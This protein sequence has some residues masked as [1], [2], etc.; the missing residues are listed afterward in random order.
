[1]TLSKVANETDYGWGL[2]ELMSI[3]VLWHC[4]SILWIEYTSLSFS[5]GNNFKEDL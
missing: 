3:I 4:L 5:L 2:S 1:V